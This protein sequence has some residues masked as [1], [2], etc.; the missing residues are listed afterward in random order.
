MSTLLLPLLDVLLIRLKDAGIACHKEFLVQTQGHI[1]FGSQVLIISNRKRGTCWFF[2]CSSMFDWLHDSKQVFV[3]E[4]DLRWTISRLLV[5]VI[6]MLV[7][8][9]FEWGKR[10]D[11]LLH[12]IIKID[13]R[14]ACHSKIFTVTNHSI[15]Q[16]GLHTFVSV[17]VLSFPV[18]CESVLRHDPRTHYYW[19]SC[20][21]LLQ[22]FFSHLGTKGISEEVF[23]SANC[24]FQYFSLLILKR[25][26]WSRL[27]RAGYWSF[28][29]IVDPLSCW[30]NC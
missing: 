25:S 15:S 3:V 22:L 17:H 14:F 20:S 1:W 4:R 24:P 7:I 27:V 30:V 21:L 5:V 28:R 9:L 12:N 8:L 6:I 10:C 26:H 23:G 13:L 18:R 16:T 29:R 19:S 2:I 11:T